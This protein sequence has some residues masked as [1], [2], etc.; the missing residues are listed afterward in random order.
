MPLFLLPSSLWRRRPAT[1]ASPTTSNWSRSL[2]KTKAGSTTS[3]K[4]QVTPYHHN[5][6]QPGVCCRATIT[7]T[8]C[9]RWASSTSLISSNKFQLLGIMSLL[10][11]KSF[12][13]L[14]Y[15]YESY[16]GTILDQSIHCY[17]LP[18]YLP[19]LQSDIDTSWTHRLLS[20]S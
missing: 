18:T 14:N 16:L 11:F 15:S 2:L 19:L 17:T 3:G 10:H 4:W 9:T 7:S 12:G 20:V 1:A 6:W 8:K 5:S 13:F